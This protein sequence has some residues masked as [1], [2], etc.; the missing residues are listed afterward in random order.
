MFNKTQNGWSQSL[1][2][3][4]LTCSGLGPVILWDGVLFSPEGRG[5]G[6]GGVPSPLTDIFVFDVRSVERGSKGTDV[7]EGGGPCSVIATYGPAGRQ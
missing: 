2:C 1:H 6:G 4:L 3:V 7:A 5:G